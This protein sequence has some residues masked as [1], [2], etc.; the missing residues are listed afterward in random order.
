MVF[1]FQVALELRQRADARAIELAD[2]ALGDRIDRR[3]IDEM[4]LL[5]A[6]PQ[7]RDEIGLAEDRSVLGDGL[8][9]HAEAPAKLDQRP[10]VPRLQQVQQT[11][12]ARL[13]QSAENS[14]IVV[15]LE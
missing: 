1:S 14:V 6:E 7:K 3:R 4:Q 5:A 13:C 9:G 10:P 11:P 8:A 15:H 12:A 2:P